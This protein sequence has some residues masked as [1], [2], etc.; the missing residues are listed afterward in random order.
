MGNLFFFFFFN[1]GYNKSSQVKFKFKV[2]WGR[3]AGKG[4]CLTPCKKR[5]KLRDL[6]L[7]PTQSG[8]IA[9]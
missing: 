9:R 4:G 3:F 5:E 6:R 8:E 2:T 1:V 7:V